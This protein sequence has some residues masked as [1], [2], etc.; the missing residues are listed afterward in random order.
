MHG[1]YDLFT[2]MP[3]K[4][5]GHCGWPS[6]S[7]LARRMA[8]G[9][10]EVADCVYLNMPEYAENKAKVK[11]LLKE[12]LKIK[13]RMP[14]SSEKVTY[15]RPCTTESGKVTA[16]AHLML[17]FVEGNELKYGLFDPFVL[18]DFL[19]NYQP[20]E[21][22]RCSEKMGIARITYNGKS[23]LLYRNGKIKVRKAKDKDDI[24]ATINLIS[25][26]MWGSIICPDCGC[27]VVDCASGGCL[28][29]LCPVLNTPPVLDESKILP[30]KKVKV[31]EIFQ[32]LDNIENK[33]K[34]IVGIKKL[35]KTIKDFEKL[36]DN[37]EGIYLEDFNNEMVKISLD[38]IVKTERVEDAVLGIVLIGISRDLKRAVEAA[39]ISVDKNELAK[40][41][42]ELVVDSYFAFKNSDLEK[43]KEIG[44]RYQK[45]SKKLTELKTKKRSKPQILEI[46]KMAR[47]GANIARILELS[48]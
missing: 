16:T 42:G 40:E 12:G 39:S 24:F 38:F 2:S 48:L 27:D 20:F 3:L 31:S 21:D 47:Q 44:G 32:R 26:I 43:G 18:C 19:K 45:L 22:I 8:A 5:C 1:F 34:F 41:A 7:T 14:T 10:S 30:R 11:S 17:P 9:D 4:N 13:V 23:I 28:A 25:R 46:E 36:I 33:D 6:C 35:E 15:V 29:T 37:G